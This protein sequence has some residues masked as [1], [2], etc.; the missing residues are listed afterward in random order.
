MAEHEAHSAIIEKIQGASP[1]SERTIEVAV[2]RLR[3]RFE[4]A[5]EDW[6][7]GG[8][9]DL[10]VRDVWEYIVLKRLRERKK[11]ELLKSAEANLRR[12]PQLFGPSDTK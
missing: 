11:E 6:P 8:V 10:L 1:S 2:S 9:R 5:G 12:D 3:E 4:D 7:R